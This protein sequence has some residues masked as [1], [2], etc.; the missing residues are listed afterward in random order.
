MRFIKLSVQT[1]DEKSSPNPYD[2]KEKLTHLETKNDMI[3][4][5]NDLQR[6]IHV[7]PTLTVSS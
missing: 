7:W 1:A 3:L 6:C 2:T 5:E 4:K